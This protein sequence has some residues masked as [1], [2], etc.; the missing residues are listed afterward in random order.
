MSYEDAASAVVA[1]LNAG[2]AEKKGEEGAPEVAGQVF[3]AAE[4]APIGRQKICEIA[5]SHPFC[6]TGKMPKFDGDNDDP[7]VQQTGPRKVYDSSK[8][9]RVL[10][11]APKYSSMEQLFTESKDKIMAAQ[12]LAAQE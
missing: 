7:L 10:G 2:I 12:E 9:R 4:D 8:T 11:W 5:L 6:Y 1:A 3:L